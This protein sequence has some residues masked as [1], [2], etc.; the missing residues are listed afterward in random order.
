MANPAV[1][2]TQVFPKFLNILFA[3]DFSRCSE[4]ALPFA[5]AIARGYGSTLHLVHI[6]GEEPMVGPL[7]VPIRDPEPEREAARLQ[8][9]RLTRSA[10]LQD[11][12]HT[13]TL[14]RGEVWDVVARLTRE[15]HVDLI[16]L[17]THGRRGL[18]HFVMG[19]VAERIF[20]HANC[21]V[22]TVGPEVQKSGLLT[23]RIGSILYATDFSPGS[24]HAFEYALSLARANRAALSLVHAIENDV[25]LNFVDESIT[26]VKERLEQLMPQDPGIRHN[27]IA[28]FGTPTDMILKTARDVGAELIVMGARKGAS[29]AAHAPWATAHK[30]IC[31]ASCPV[32]TVHG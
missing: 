30:V 11:V 10:N 17:G 12:L 19:S 22:L 14:E 27:L 26:I 21:P 16:V 20:R 3:T 31:Y 8:M 24:L 28:E 1:L 25:L 13:V 23:G 2:L 32:L 7:G 5:R 18:K 9:D 29:G 6:I 15:L 4:S